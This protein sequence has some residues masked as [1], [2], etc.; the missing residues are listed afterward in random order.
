MGFGVWGVWLGL[1]KGFGG[2]FGGWEEGWWGEG[3]KSSGWWGEG[4]WVNRGWLVYGGNGVGEPWLVN[5]G[6][7]IEGALWLL[8]KFSSW[9][10]VF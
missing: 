6:A 7:G 8:M 9:E 5:W 1:L 3:Q 2:G 10:L 4:F